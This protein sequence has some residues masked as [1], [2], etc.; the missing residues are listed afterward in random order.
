MEENLRELPSLSAPGARGFMRRLFAG[1]G[2]GTIDMQGR[3]LIPSQLCKHAEIKRDVVIAGV[4]TRVEIWCKERWEEYMEQRR[5][6]FE[7]I[8]AGLMEFN[9]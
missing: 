1:T 5:R 9:I 7:D 3:I 6:C 2:E 4:L 8:A